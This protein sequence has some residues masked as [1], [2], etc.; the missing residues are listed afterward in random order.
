MESRRPGWWQIDVQAPVFMAL[1]SRG[2]NLLI[3]LMKL[4][5]KKGLLVSSILDAID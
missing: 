5:C 3:V 2:H 1:A 4:P